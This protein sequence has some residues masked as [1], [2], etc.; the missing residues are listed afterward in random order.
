MAVV[1]RFRRGFTIENNQSRLKTTFST[2]Q[3]YSRPCPIHMKC[4]EPRL[5]WWDKIS[6]K[7]TQE[8]ILQS[9][10]M[11]WE[12]SL[13]QKSFQLIL[14][15]HSVWIF[16]FYLREKFWSCE[17]CWLTLHALSLSGWHSSVWAQAWK[18]LLLTKELNLLTVHC[19][20]TASCSMN[21]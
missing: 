5:W 16:I 7:V 1:A 18:Q 11:I 6:F 15:F 4:L 2:I 8:K 17:K 19:H 9:L 20:R 3:L 12:H 14:I 21:S 13:I 10:N